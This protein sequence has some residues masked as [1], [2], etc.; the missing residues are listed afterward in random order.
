[1]CLRI[2]DRTHKAQRCDH[3]CWE[4]C[5]QLRGW[6][7]VTRVTFKWIFSMI[8]CHVN[9]NCFF[10]VSLSL[11]SCVAQCLSLINVASILWHIL[12]VCC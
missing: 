7:S 6:G 11:F 4:S 5:I 12:W 8:L 9:M 3:H 2:I 1:M 10:F